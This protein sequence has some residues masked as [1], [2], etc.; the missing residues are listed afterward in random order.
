MKEF[1]MSGA[2]NRSAFRECLHWLAETSPEWV[3][4][5]IDLIIKYGRWDDIRSLNQTKAEDYGYL[6]WASAIKEKDGLACK[7]ADRKDKKL[8]KILR[9]DKTVND[10]GDFRRLLAQGRENI[11]ER[12]MCANKWDNI[13][14][15]KVPSVAMSRY[16]KAFSKHDENRFQTFKDKVE[17]GEEKINASVLFP[18]DL[19]TTVLN[20]D[21]QTADLQFKALPNWMSKSD[22]RILTICDTSGSMSAIIGGSV[23]AWFVSTSLALYCS[24][25]ISET[26]PFHRKFL[27]FC[28]ESK[29]TDWSHLKFSECFN[30][31]GYAKSSLFNGAV[32]ST[33]IDLALNSILNYAKQFN[34]T[35]EQMPNLL[36]IISDMQFSEGSTRTND[37]VIENCMNEWKKAGYTTPKIVYWNV[38]GCAGQP[39]DVTHK[40]VGL[41]SGFSPSILEAIFSAT[42]FTPKGIMMEKIKKYEVNIPK[43]V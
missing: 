18:H 13:N 34:A 39:A 15:S 5:N 10:I 30:R 4:A 40:N 16:T 17:N 32:G 20:G 25:R 38:A 23:A 27:Q 33:R 8:L 12:S 36:L 22:L 37:T 1:I 11:V 42:D 28:D 26:S 35:N 19:V 7:W 3:I 43:T 24:D 41:V 21:A 6:V 31:R 29:L 9:R 2:G 14:Y